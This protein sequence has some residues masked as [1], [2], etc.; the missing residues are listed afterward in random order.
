M[1]GFAVDFLF[2]FMIQLYFFSFGRTTPIYQKK[3]RAY[4]LV[5]FCIVASIIG[6]FSVYCDER[7]Q[8]MR[9]KNGRAIR[10]TGIDSQK[11]LI[12]AYIA[13][14]NNNKQVLQQ[15]LKVKT[16]KFQLPKQNLSLAQS[17][18]PNAV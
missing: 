10:N 14:N 2:E 17:W 9:K 13:N 8:V 7:K 18:S 5:R 11:A 12:C 6:C 16:R 4:D 3:K 1:E 15:F